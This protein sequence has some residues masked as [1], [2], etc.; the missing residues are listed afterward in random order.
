VEKIDFLILM[1]IGDVGLGAFF[2]FHGCFQDTVH[3]LEKCSECTK[4][5]VFKKIYKIMSGKQHQ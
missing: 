2:S 5:S 3:S 1:Y 4:R